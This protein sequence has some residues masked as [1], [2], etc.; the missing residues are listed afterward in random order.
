[1]KKFLLI[2]T[3]VALLR[4]DGSLWP[5][6]GD[7]E[8]YSSSQVAVLKKIPDGEELSI[9]VKAVWSHDYNGFAWIVPI[10]SE[11]QIAETDEQLFTDL[12]YMSAPVYAGGGCSP[13]ARAEPLSEGATLGEDYID[14][15][16][17]HTIGFLDAV[18]LHT[19]HADSLI[20]WLSTNGYQI[21]NGA[22][23][24]LNDYIDR[25]WNYF[26]CA[27]VDTA[28]L[29]TYYQNVGVKITFETDNLV[30]PMKISALSSV[31]HV[32]VYLYIIDQHKMYFEGAELEYAN[33]LTSDELDHITRD[34][35]VLS[36]YV[37][38]E[39]YITKLKTVYAEPADISS[40]IYLYQSPDDTEYQEFWD[41]YYGSI[42]FGNSYLL[43]LFLYI[44]YIGIK[45]I[46]LKKY[47]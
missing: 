35:P 15:V 22:D 17:Y 16:S 11:P 10:P 34:F 3:I 27:R 38:E 39:D 9:L 40:D 13:F 31:D 26:F 45:K 12:A 19:N 37:S 46:R 2:L 32:E 7:Y 30:Y 20:N 47:R 18:V 23:D 33:R 28:L 6:Q 1:M 41:P 4:A 14:V 25:D 29:E 8:I 42:T 21:M 24:M 5:P 36:D 43:P 44:L